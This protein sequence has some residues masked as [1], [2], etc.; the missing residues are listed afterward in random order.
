MDEHR[1][2]IVEN[3][4]STLRHHK[5]HAPMVAPEQ[6]DDMQFMDSF[7]ELYE[8]SLKEVHEGD[9]V[10]GEVVEV[11]RNYV[12]VDI[13]L[14]SE[15]LIPAQEFYDSKGNCCVKLGEKI[16][17]L[18]LQK[19]DS[20]GCCRLSREKAETVRN[21]EKIKSAH[22]K[23]ATIKGRII[24][25]IK[26]GYAVDIGLQ[27]FLPGS[28]VGL[29]PVRDVDALLGKEYDFKILNL[30]LSRNN[31]VL[32]RRVILEAER[33]VLR[34]KTLKALQDGAVLDGTVKNIT[35]YGLFVDLGGIDGL[36][37]ITDICWHRLGHPSELYRIEDKIKVK[38]LKIDGE[39]ISLGIKQLTPDP[40]EGADGRYPEGAKIK[41]RVVNL[42]DY[43]AFVEIEK[44]LEGLIHVSE[45]SWT[46]KVKHPSQ[47]LGVGDLVD[48][49][50][51][52]N[53][54]TNKRIS[55]SMKQFETNPWDVI[56]S[57]YP[58]GTVI[59][60]RVR[61][62]VDFG[63]FL[64][65]PEGIDGLVHI[66]DISWAGRIAHPSEYYK[67]GQE[68]A[69]VILKVDKE[70]QRL[71]LGIKQLTPDP[72]DMI[73]ERYKPGTSVTGIVTHIADFG[74]FVELEKGLE[75]LIH[76]SQIQK[77]G[78]ENALAHFDVDDI[79]KARVIDISRHEKKIKLSMLEL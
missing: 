77:N 14:K 44:G 60:G 8:K 67:E 37:H 41:G 21:L 78:Q 27:A 26:G 19:E 34:E 2:N 65:L 40:W 11:G 3:S 51:L 71:S 5:D 48:A 75:G 28:Q 13:G 15:G 7:K 46:R 24:S 59:K 69:A 36:V 57:K 1:I 73:P 61:N 54:A 30:N 45:I 56:A 64:G 9:I 55:L 31:I 18:L 38:V 79:I 52:K 53:D 74:L 22:E 50:I 10:Q 12:L 20:D 47:F 4:D 32:S 49:V 17:V 25:Q 23:G 76:V 39:K 6:P 72:W 68:V 43:G 35:G 16:D 62:V 29:R 63:I 66:S 58:P 42:T 33:V 70:N